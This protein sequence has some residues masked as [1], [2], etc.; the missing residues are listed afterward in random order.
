MYETA[1]TIVGMVISSVDRQHT[2]RTGT[3]M[4][5]F[6]VAST[7]RRFDKVTGRW[8]DGESLYL[9][10]TCWRQLADNVSASLAQGDPVVVTGRLHTRSYLDRDGA[11]RWTFELAAFAVGHD[12]A[13]GTAAFTRVARRADPERTAAGGVVG[14]PALAG[15]ALV[16]GGSEE[17]GGG[18][19][20]DWL[21]DGSG[22]AGA[23]R[24]ADTG[25]PDPGRSGGRE[26]VELEEVAVGVA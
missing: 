6:R 1:L 17:P 8:A 16:A 25:L 22:G 3:A 23:D 14:L 20:A 7:S 24:A 18:P 5:R 4:C 10:V 19:A 9:T 15:A 26:P 21:G 2:E 12:L 13:R 11:R